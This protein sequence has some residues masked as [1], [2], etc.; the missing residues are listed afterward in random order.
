MTFARAAL[1]AVLALFASNAFADTPKF[2]GDKARAAELWKQFE[3]WLVAYEKADLD[4][5]M[6]IFAKDAIF[7]FQGA[8]DAGYDDLEAAYVADFASRKPGSKWVPIAEEV[9]AE[10]T[11]A[12]VRSRWEMQMP[13]GKG[14]IT[15]KERNR[16][17]DV[18]KWTKDGWRLIRSLNYQEN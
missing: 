17:L 3:H 4:G 2:S 16:G 18:F 1:L 5:V 6:E 8:P 15:T 12:I 7:S 10:G 11:M 14:G 13:D 9:Y